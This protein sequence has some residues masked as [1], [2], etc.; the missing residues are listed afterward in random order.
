MSGRKSTV[1]SLP[2]KS[3][4]PLL[5]AKPWGKRGKKEENSSLKVREVEKV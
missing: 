3:L 4:V 5:P 1:Y 2:Y